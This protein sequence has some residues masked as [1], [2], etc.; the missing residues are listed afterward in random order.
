MN[1]L[2]VCDK[3]STFILNEII[4]LR[5]RGNRV[6]VLPDRSDR[7]PF[8]EYRRSIIIERGLLDYVLY[9]PGA[10]ASRKEKIAEFTAAILHDVRF[11]PAALVRAL[12]LITRIYADFR[13]AAEDYLDVRDLCEL[14]IDLIHAPFA[15]PRIL[16]RT[17]FISRLF[18]VPYTLAFR[19][20]D[21][22]LP[23]SLERART[24]PGVQNA[25]RIVTISQYNRRHIMDVLGEAQVVDVVHSAIDTNYFT[26]SRPPASGPRIV[27]IARYDEQK[28]LTHLIRA[29]RIL[30]DR[31]VRYT[32]TVIGD[33]A[34]GVEKRR[35]EELIKLLSVPDVHLNELATQVAV[36]ETL[37]DATLFVLPCVIASN[38]RRD[39]LANA[40]KEAMAMQ[41][42]VVTSNICGIEELVEDGISGILVPPADPASLA[43]ALQRLLTCP[44]EVRERMGAAG[45]RKVQS[46]FNIK[47]EAAR[48]ERIFGDAV[49]SG[50]AGSELRAGGVLDSTSANV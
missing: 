49:R 18:Q 47:R 50:N 41:L 48:L 17:F 22:Y 13:T 32:C 46:E 27:S 42:P 25:A 35:C 30:A 40:L 10:Y 37:Q 7:W 11:R 29:L 28:G 19:A 21:I 33:V 4:E 3:L 16:D 5:D 39:I 26:R 38:G 43:E 44:R 34:D 31:N 8:R 9:R 1:V 6:Y 14:E 23:G 20:H 24:S 2:Y 45:R 36:R 12:Y 15:T